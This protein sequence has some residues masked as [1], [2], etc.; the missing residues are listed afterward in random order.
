MLR[1]ATNYRDELFVLERLLDVIE[2][3]IVHR[4]DRRLKARLRRHEN[5]NRLGVVRA[6]G[7]QNIQAGDIGHSD[8]SDYQLGLQCGNLLQT[9]LP[10]E[11]RVGDESLALEQNADRV[12]YAHLVIDD[13]NRRSGC[14]GGGHYSLFARNLGVFLAPSAPSLGRITVNLVP[15][16]GPSLSTRI[17]P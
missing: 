7:S 11:S 3:A 1:R 13:E 14:R 16:R 10:S 9:L 17:K 2:G 5:H 6:H 4:A 15:D 12:E 8:V